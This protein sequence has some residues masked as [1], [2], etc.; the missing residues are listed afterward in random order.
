MI[1][2]AAQAITSYYDGQPLGTFGQ[3]STFSFHETKNISA[4]EGGLL[5]VNDPTLRER[6][7]I[8]REKGTNRTAFARG[9]T[10]KYTWVDVGS[11]F[12]P[13]EMT[14]A[15]LW[16]QLEQVATIQARRQQLW[17][18]YYTLLQP[19]AAA[20]VAQLPLVPVGATNN[21]HIFYVVCRSLADRT[22][23]LHHLRQT[24]ILAVFHYQALHQSPFYQQQHG[25][26]PLPHAERYSN[27]L[28]RLPLYVELTED[29]VAHIA[30]QVRTC[31]LG[32][33]SA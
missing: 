1:E 19:L 3:L 30:Q 15:F 8:I 10:D 4:G 7:E 14:A 24:G 26:R 13:S 28:V 5:A 6:A 16:A 9:E 11:S 12:L 31:L 2:D 17:D 25:N 23:L 22:R 27:C 33:Y 32:N 29:Q 20:G 21:A 18:L